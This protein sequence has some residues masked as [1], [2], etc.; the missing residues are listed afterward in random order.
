MP[1]VGAGWGLD[2]DYFMYGEDVDWCWRFHAAKWRVMYYPSSE[3]IH[4]GGEFRSGA[5][6]VFH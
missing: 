5:G 1:G 6:E 4:F 3:A 2:E